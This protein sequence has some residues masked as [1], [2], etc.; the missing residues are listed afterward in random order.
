MEAVGT[1]ADAGA[2]EPRQDLNA[3][4]VNLTA[5]EH[6]AP[7]LFQPWVDAG[8]SLRER[9]YGRQCGRTSRFL[10]ISEDGISEGDLCGALPNY[11]TGVRTS[12]DIPKI[13]LIRFLFERSFGDPAD[14]SNHAVK[15]FN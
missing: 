7:G 15:S 1:G 2:D 9:R 13:S 8:A 12:L 11:L 10:C 6:S 4:A 3:A 14:L 5:P